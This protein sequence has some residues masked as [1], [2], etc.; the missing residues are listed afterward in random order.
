M[1]LP[2]RFL[3]LTLAFFVICVAAWQSASAQHGGWSFGGG[4]GGGWGGGGHQYRQSYGHNYGH[5]YNYNR[6]YGHNYGHTYRQPQYVPPRTNVVPR[7]NPQPQRTY[8]APKTNVI[9]RKNNVAVSPNK[10]PVA[11]KTA[12]KT[13]VVT[14]PPKTTAPKTTAPVP[15]NLLP[16]TKPP[17]TTAAKNSKPKLPLKPNPGKGTFVGNLTAGDLKQIA[18]QIG[19]RGHQLL[20]QAERV[21]TSGVGDLI[22]QLPGG[23][24][25]TP[26]Q[27]AAINEAI[28]NG[29][30]EV[31]RRLLGEGATSPAGQELVDRATAMSAV[32]GAADAIADGTFDGGD[33]AAL[34][35]I[36]TIINITGPDLQTLLATIGQVAIGQQVVIWVQ[37]TDPGVGLVPFGPDIPIVLVP[38]LPDGLLM[39]MDDGVV[40]IGMGAPGDA[41]MLGMGD[42]LEVA[43]LPVPMDGA[44]PADATTRTFE[45]GQIILANPTTETVNYNLNQQPYQMAPDFEQTLPAGTTWEIEFDRGGSFG[46]ARYQLSEGYYVFAITERGWD[47]YKR[48]FAATLD[49]SSN[50]FAF[51][52]V[53][54]DQQQTLNP[55][56]SQDLTGVFPPV[57]VFDNGNGQEQRR[58]LESDAYEVA[59]TDSL[60]LDIFRAE[61]TL[62]PQAPQPA[63][64]APVASA[65]AATTPAP[66]AAA[67]T[68]A[69]RAP[70]APLPVPTTTARTTPAPTATPD[71]NG[72]RL[73]QGFKLFDPVAALTEPRSARNLPQSFTLFRSAAEQRPVAANR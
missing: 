67:P 31:L 26:A 60:T 59:V 32:D 49:N 25:L 64:T 17:A 45:Q 44:V 14:S 13:N 46:T 18:K 7:S 70:M 29:D 68:T 16:A 9:P 38:G 20:D 15:N 48:S 28:A 43:G 23:A 19:D 4:W 5:N 35:N 73:P 54:D 41:I 63:A 65:P 71:A 21:L 27:V 47:I 6:G 50:S 39:P 52:Y 57:I 10:P 2:T 12:P 72:R 69:A 56:E 3:T 62:V 42:P 34:I 8:V 53:V 11:I 51:N 40:M 61:V 33:L 1:S 36:T 24:D 30:P 37:G 66:R 22:R 55:G 58:R